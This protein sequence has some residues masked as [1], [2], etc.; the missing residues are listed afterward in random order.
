MARYMM[1]IDAGTTYT[2][3]M[4]VDHNAKIIS[5][6]AVEN[7]LYYPQPGWVEQDPDEILSATLKAAGDAFKNSRISPDDIE[8]LG[9]SNQLLT[10]IF[11]NKYTGEAVGR[12]IVWQDN[13]TSLICEQLALKDRKGIEARSGGYIFPNSSATKIRWLMEHDRAIQ[14]GVA[15]GEILFGTVDTW[16]IWKLSGGAAHVTDL[17][18]IWASLLFNTH[19][20]CYDEWMLRELE[21][22]YEILPELHSSSEI[23]AFTKPELFFDTRIPIAGDAGDQFAA[24]FGQGCYQPGVLTCTL[25]TGASLALN[26]GSQFIQ[27]GGGLAAPILWSIDGHVT[28]GIGGWTNVSGAAVQWLRNELGLIHDDSEAEVFASRVPNNGGVYFVP[29]FAGL[30]GLYNDPFS[31]GTLFGITQSTTKN[32]IVRAAL[33]AMA[34]QVRDTFDVIKKLPGI[35]IEY[36]RAGG[37]GA[38]ND[39]LLQFLADML[40][41]RVERPVNIESSMMGAIFLAGLA[42]GFWHSTDEIQALVKVERR[43]EPIIS[44][45]EREELYHGWKKA[46]ERSLGWMKA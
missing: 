32:H 3:A 11:W 44:V 30:V 29:A 39:F 9:I 17:S 18:N 46:I 24:V 26:T 1:G 27:P 33:E 41:I 7:K 40:E 8:A 4:I 5:S 19:T 22:P 25:G 10:T 13:R 28:R 23:Y 2:K 16:L 45:E 12:A 34:Y 15:R 6:A 14:K 43:W 21:I 36:L 20:L 42:T 38:R 31:R 37:G 35:K